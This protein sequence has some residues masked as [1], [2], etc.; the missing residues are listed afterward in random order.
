[1]IA[2]NAMEQGVHDRQLRGDR[3]P[4]AL[5]LLCRHLDRSGAVK[6]GVQLISFYKYAGPDHVPRLADAFQCTASEA[7]VHGAVVR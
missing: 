2:G 1:M 7:E 5:G 4:A 3:L 6:V